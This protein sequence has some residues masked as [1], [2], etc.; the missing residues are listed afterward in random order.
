MASQWQNFMQNLGEWRGSFAT[1]TA[2]GEVG[3]LSPS[4]LTSGAYALRWLDEK[5]SLK[6]KMVVVQ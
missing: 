5:S 4:I 1:L 6:V 2:A 3:D